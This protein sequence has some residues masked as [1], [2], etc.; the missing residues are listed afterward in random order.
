MRK[1]S[2]LILSIL[3]TVAIMVS[4]CGASNVG[5]SVKSP[6]DGSTNQKTNESVTNAPK[7]DDELD[8]NVRILLGYNVSLDNMPAGESINNNFLYD[9]VKEKTGFNPTY[10][11]LPSEGGEQKISIIIASGD[12]P[13]I[14]ECFDRGVFNRFAQSGALLPLDDILN[15]YGSE[16]LKFDKEAYQACKIDGSIMALPQPAERYGTWGV[17]VREDILKESGIKELKTRDDYVNFFRYAKEEKGMFGL[18][19]WG[20]DL[21]GV[22]AFPGITSG[23]GLGSVLLEKEDGNYEWS[24]IS[25][26]AKEYIVWMKHIFDEGLLDPDFPVFT[27]LEVR[28]RLSSENAAAGTLNYWDLKT[29]D[30]NMDKVGKKG[31]FQFAHPMVD[32]NGNFTV[33]YKGGP[34]RLYNLVPAVAKNPEG[35]IAFYNAMVSNPE[36]VK[37]LA[38]GFEDV[39]YTVNNGNIEATERAVEVNPYTPY[40]MIGHTTFEDR[41]KVKGFWDYYEPLVAMTNVWDYFDM[42]PPVAEVSD[43]YNELRDYAAENAVKFILGVR[44]IDEWDQ[45]VKEFNSMGGQA[46]IDAINASK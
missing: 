5:G 38:F 9:Y 10:E 39:H 42:M 1:K 7:G 41:Q 29:V 35:A 21:E 28:E 24:Y 26:N 20:K 34:V 33:K 44:P 13:D 31:V 16:L 3:L 43:N 4:G 22:F 45:Y 40:L 46:A 15:E 36:I 8:K 30:D 11:L 37:T 32:D 23:F 18:T 2:L 6:T 19:G 17:A 27:G 25:D 12:T 14:I